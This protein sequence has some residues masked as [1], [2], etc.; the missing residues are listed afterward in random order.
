MLDALIFL[1]PILHNDVYDNDI[2]NINPYWPIQRM[3]LIT[4]EDEE[5]GNIQNMSLVPCDKE[6]EHLITNPPQLV[7]LSSMIG[8][9]QGCRRRYTAKDRMKPNDFVFKYLTYC[10]QYRKKERNHYKSPRYF[11]AYDL[12]CM[13]RYDKLKNVQMDE[14]YMSNTTF[15]TLTR[16]HIMKLKMNN[17]WDAIIRN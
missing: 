13:R 2:G 12:G 17:M 1:S 4:R 7:F 3:F 8:I 5:N 16:D 9:C 10:D 6:N 15:H 14:I 11:H